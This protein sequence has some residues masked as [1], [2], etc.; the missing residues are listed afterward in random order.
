[1]NQLVIRAGDFTFEACF[2]DQLAPRPVPRSPRDAVRSQ[3]VHVRGAARGSLPLGDLDF[4]VGYENP[5]AIP[6]RVRSSLSGRCQRDRILLAYGGVH[7]ASK[8]VSRRKP[9]HHVDIRT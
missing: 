1:M 6:R 3:M 7:F 2:E 9:F 4:G 8:W 5:P